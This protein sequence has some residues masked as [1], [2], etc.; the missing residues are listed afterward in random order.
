MPFVPHEA[1]SAAAPSE[2]DLALA[3][4]REALTGD[5]LN[6]VYQPIVDLRSGTTL[7]AEALARFKSTPYR[8]PDVWFAEAQLLGLGVELELHAIELALRGLAHMPP[9]T[10]LTLNA[11]PETLLD[12]RLLALLRPYPGERLVLELT[13]HARVVDYTP[14][15]EAIGRIRG[16]KARIAVDDAGAGFASFQHIVTLRPDIIKLD[17]SLTTGLDGNPVRIAL[18]SSLV[19]F[20]SSLGARICAEG[21]ETAGELTALQKLGIRKGQG[22]F[23]ARPG[24]LPLP[25]IPSGPWMSSPRTGLPDSPGH[26]LNASL[27]TTWTGYLPSPVVRSPERLQA[28]KSTG[29]MDSPREDEFDAITELAAT[30][31]KVPVTMISLLDDEHQFMK[32]SFGLPKEQ[33][34]VPLAYSLCQHVVS[35][36]QPLII[37]DTRLHALIQDSPAVKELNVLAYAGV[38]LTTSD[39]QTLGTLCAVD[40]KPR[41]WDT[42]DVN[43]LQ[44]LARTVLGVIELRTKLSKQESREQMLDALFRQ[45]PAATVV[46]DIRGRIVRMN[47]RAEELLGRTE[48]ECVSLHISAL[49]HPDDL[50]HDMARRDDLLS[51]RIPSLI[52]DTRYLR[53]DG[54]VVQ[55]RTELT[56]VRGKESSALFT[57]ATMTRV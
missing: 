18:A 32:S 55:L 8:T 38:P 12:E 19:T 26:A 43:T 25:N 41:L 22:Y 53:A 10:Y 42:Q 16:L 40:V 36:T 21:I 27:K 20:A 17:R 45:S 6:I 29:L 3:R 23:L 46:C 47:G 48:A 35:Q 24:P 1:A 44:A 34:E 33:R 28:L 50:A 5:V 54:S 14:L 9:R 15:C 2:S 39:D 30:L 13:E 49:K 11:S 56:V 51:G 31:L 7:G 37:A 57:L 4:I 52:L